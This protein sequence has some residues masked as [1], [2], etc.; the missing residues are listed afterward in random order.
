MEQGTW[1]D[2]VVQLLRRSG[3]GSFYRLQYFSRVDSTNEAVKRAAELSPGSG[4]DP[5][6]Y[7]GEGLVIIGEEQTAGKGRR[8]RSWASPSGESIYFSV[9]LRPGI[10]AEACSAVTL[11]AGLSVAQTLRKLYGLDARIKWPNDIVVEGKKVCG[12]LTEGILEGNTLAGAVTGIGI[13]VNNRSF[14]KEIAHRATSVFL[15][16][17]RAGGRNVSSEMIADRAQLLASVL[18]IFRLY[19]AVFC[20]DGSMGSLREEYMSLLAGR[21][22]SV[23][24][25]D[26]AGS[27][28]GKCLGIDDRGCLLIER[29]D[30]ISVRVSSGEVSVRGIYDYV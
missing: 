21:G 12:I 1:A 8:G 15:E 17:Q 9:L 7:A 28:S 29:E 27:Y 23:V 24:I 5:S 16:I 10:P 30:G 25:E 22:S 11:V 19:Y 4:S 2:E 14:P 6:E 3:D 13:N 26:P 18:H 20:E